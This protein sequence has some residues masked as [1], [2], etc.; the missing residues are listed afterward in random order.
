MIKKVSG[1]YILAADLNTITL[2]EQDVY[3]QCDTSLAPVNI[4]FPLI[5]D[6]KGSRNVKIYI[7]DESKNASV[8]NITLTMGAGDL[9]N[10]LPSIVINQDGYSGKMDIV[11]DTQWTL[12]AVGTG[13][14]SASVANLNTLFVSPHGNDTTAL[15]GRIDKPFLTIDAAIAAITGNNDCVYVYSGIYTPSNLLA[16]LSLAFNKL[17]VFC[18]PGVLL[19]VLS[20]YLF[21]DVASAYIV[22]FTG[23]AKINMFGSGI[24]NI[25]NFSIINLEYDEDISGSAQTFSGTLGIQN[26]TA[27][28]S[29]NNI[30]SI[31]YIQ[32][33]ATININIDEI[34]NI[35]LLRNSAFYFD[36]CTAG[37][38]TINFRTLTC[39]PDGAQ[40]AI[41]MTA[42]SSTKVIVRG[43]IIIPGPFVYTF[44]SGALALLNGGYIDFKG[45]IDIQA[46]FGAWGLKIYGNAGIASPFPN[47]VFIES[48]ISIAGNLGNNPAISVNNSNSFVTIKNS[49]IAGNNTIDSLEVGVLTVLDDD[50]NGSLEV[51]DTEIINLFDD[52]G[53]TSNTT[54]GISGGT[55]QMANVTINNLNTAAGS[56]SIAGIV[57]AQNIKV[58][59]PGISTN[60]AANV[61]ITN[62]IAGTFIIVDPSILIQNY[63]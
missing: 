2:E 33:S 28:K 40:A 54:I 29:Q 10:D 24:T 45:N 19:N 35:N 42:C 5:S 31:A 7:V 14:G 4:Q 37:T 49:L 11:G 17:N 20:G 22:N 21:D 6:Y 61:N 48:N 26:I 39:N 60:V 59:S 47:Q 51:Y 12:P 32:G 9:V 44:L 3:L 50:N 58:L 27:R 18:E 55:L 41:F 36:T 63:N 52:G 56:T 46:R 34:I 16:N 53:V 15:K 13:S 57:G 30:Q 1:N 62:T 43:N 25:N 23:L 8:N 38:S